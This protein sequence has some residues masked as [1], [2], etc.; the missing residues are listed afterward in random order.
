MDDKRLIEKITSGD[1]YAF[2][3][4]VEKYHPMVLT[5]C[6][7]ILHNFEDSMDVSQEVFIKIYESIDQFR[8]DSKVSTW[9]YRIAVNKSLNFLRSKKRNRWFNSLDLIF[10]D[11]KAQQDPADDS[12]QPGEILETDENKK[13]LHDALK[14]LPEKQNAA[15]A[16][17]H[18]EDLS[19]KEIAEIMDI[20]VTEVGVLINRGKK[21]LQKTIIDYYKKN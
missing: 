19:Y 2:Q 12:P 10:G 9:L 14:K 8:G 21:K 18:F 15:I 20:S 17:S 7:N 4:F 1:E 11:D 3:L 16:L 6:N 13:V 5:I